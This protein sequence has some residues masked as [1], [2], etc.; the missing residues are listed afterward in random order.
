L[1]LACLQKGLRKNLLQGGA[2]ALVCLLPKTAQQLVGPLK[3]TPQM[4]DE[5]GDQRLHLKLWQ[6]RGFRYIAHQI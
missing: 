2:L 5:G 3:K 4:G 1:L 6:Q